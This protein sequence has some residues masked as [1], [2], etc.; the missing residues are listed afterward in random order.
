MCGEEDGGD[1]VVSDKSALRQGWEWERLD[2]SKFAVRLTDN[3]SVIE[4]SNSAQGDGHAEVAASAP[5][6]SPGRLRNK[7]FTLALV[8][9]RDLGGRKHLYRHLEGVGGLLCFNICICVYRSLQTFTPSIH[10]LKH[11]SHR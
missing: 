11:K 9:A 10:P 1:V 8:A 6:K 4:A 2:G 3:M 5:K 7:I